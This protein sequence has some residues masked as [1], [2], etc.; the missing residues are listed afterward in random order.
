MGIAWSQNEEL[1]TIFLCKI[2]IKL[3]TLE[4]NW[5]L[6]YVPNKLYLDHLDKVMPRFPCKVIARSL[7]EELCTKV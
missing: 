2:P 7:N 3:I 5:T 4:K 1:N 6:Y